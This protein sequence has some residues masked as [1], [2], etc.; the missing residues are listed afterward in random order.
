MLIPFLLDT[1]ASLL[2]IPLTKKGTLSIN[3][4]LKCTGTELKDQSEKYCRIQETLSIQRSFASNRRVDGVNIT[5][6][7]RFNVQAR[8][9][10]TTIIKEINPLLLKA[11]A[12]DPT[13]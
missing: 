3:I 1:Q 13:S 11:C 4:N 12:L 2:Y 7:E 5:W 6:V 10:A 9:G 8:P